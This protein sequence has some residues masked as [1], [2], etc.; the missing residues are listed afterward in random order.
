MNNNTERT[1]VELSD[2]HLE[3]VSGGVIVE[4][5]NRFWLV[6]QDGTVIAPAPSREKALEF[7]KG[8]SISTEILTREGYLK[9]F[10]RE[11]VW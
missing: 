7:A 9:R 6:R 11:L 3:D 8:F 5:G 4:D 1:F 10:G 2:L